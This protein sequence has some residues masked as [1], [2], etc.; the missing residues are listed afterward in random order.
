MT[1][2]ENI[3]R[4]R[5]ERKISQVELSQM[6]GVTQSFVSKMESD[7]RLPNL[8]VSKQLAKVLNCEIED[9]FK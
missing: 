6:I 5:K 7:A 1:I 9:F 2:G 3:K 8:V 4:I